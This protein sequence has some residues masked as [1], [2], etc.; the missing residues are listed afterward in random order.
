MLVNLGKS[1]LV[2]S[3]TL[4]HLGVTWNF[5]D[6]T[7]SCPENQINTISTEAKIIGRKGRALISRLESLLGKLVAFEKVIP[8]GRI[9]YCFFQRSVLNHLKHGRSPRYVTISL[10]ARKDFGG[11]IRTI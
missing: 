2:P 10:N 5:K 8:F 1:H 4:T 11:Q 6:A 9:N 3:E 7:I